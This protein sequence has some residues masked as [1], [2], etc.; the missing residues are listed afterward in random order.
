MKKVLVFFVVLAVIGSISLTAFLLFDKLATATDGQLVFEKINLQT[1]LTVPFDKWQAVKAQI[2]KELK[3]EEEVKT[4]TLFAAGDIMLSRAVESKMLAKND[5]NY[6][7]SPMTKL[8]T[9]ADLAFANLESPIIAGSVVPSGSFSFRANPKSAAALK[10]AGFDV[11]TLANNHFGNFGQKGMT[12]TFKY[13]DEQG[14]KYVGAGTN[15]AQMK[16]PLVIEKQGIKVAFLGYS[17]GPD[18]YAATSQAAGFALMDQGQLIKDLE[19]AKKLADL[20]IVTMHDGIEYTNDPSEHQQAFARLAVDHG[21]DL[22]IGHH[23]HVVQQMEIYKDKYIFYSLGNFVFDQMWSLDTRQGL[24]VMF[25]LDKNGVTDLDYYP[26]LIQDYC[27]P[28]LVEGKE[29]EAILG[30]L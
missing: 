19:A 18:Y 25:T 12:E 15:A 10:T 24:S 30:K 9:E 17:Y 8:I 21:A 6:C 11:L 13:L 28:N 27:Q 7:F 3:L 29:R 5:F 2:L 23:P 4:I 14:V 22:V 16:N 26:V 20:I 1:D